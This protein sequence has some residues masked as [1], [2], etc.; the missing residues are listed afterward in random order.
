FI[1]PGGLPQFATLAVKQDRLAKGSRP[2]DDTILVLPLHHVLIHS[3]NAASMNTSAI[4]TSRQCDVQAVLKGLWAEG[5]SATARPTK[6]RL[7]HI[8][9]GRKVVIPRTCASDEIKWNHVS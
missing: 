5:N 9:P 8:I 7:G 4:H 6:P 3:I 1:L 2:E